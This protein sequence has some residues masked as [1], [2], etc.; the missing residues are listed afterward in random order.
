MPGK[1][2][3]V[4]AE[5]LNQVL[6]HVI[7]ND[8]AVVFAAQ[9][10]QMELN[11]MMPVMIYNLLQSIGILTNSLEVFRIKCVDGIKAN[12]EKCREY[13]EK[14]VGLATILNTYI[15]YDNASKIAKESVETG[16]PI[17]ELILEKKLMTEKQLKEMLDAKSITEPGIPGKTKKKESKK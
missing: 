2:N 5:M 12:E 13:A 8:T 9:A 15:G 3:P 6:F 4:M 7:G 14:S 16:K 1:V 10:G 11:V 17:P